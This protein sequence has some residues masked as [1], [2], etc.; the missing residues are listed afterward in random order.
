MRT[1]EQFPKRTTSSSAAYPKRGWFCEAFYEETPF[2]M[3]VNR[4]DCERRADL[5]HMVRSLTAIYGM[6]PGFQ[7][8]VFEWIIY[9]HGGKLHPTQLNVAPPAERVGAQKAMGELM[10]RFGRRSET[11]KSDE[12]PW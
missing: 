2:H 12:E 10:T 7:I 6:L 1:E 3:V 8:D 9:A 5:D 11:L 4:K